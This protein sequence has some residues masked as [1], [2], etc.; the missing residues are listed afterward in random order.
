MTL[1][2]TI[3]TI[4]FSMPPFQR[5][6]FYIAGVRRV[7]VWRTMSG[8]PAPPPALPE[9]APAVPAPLAAVQL[10][11]EALREGPIV[12]KVK[13]VLGRVKEAV[14]KIKDFAHRH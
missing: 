12:D 3:A 6:L 13:T 4:L 1:T 5:M 9:P 10:A 11:A 7:V 14:L 8:S 2:S